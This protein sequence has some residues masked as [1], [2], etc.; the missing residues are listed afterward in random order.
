MLVPPSRLGQAT[1]ALIS[2]EDRFNRRLKYP[3]VLFTVASEF[4]DNRELFEDAKEKID[5]ITE[6]R[7]KFGAYLDFVAVAAH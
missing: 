4:K 1:E 7:A 5:A 2:V 6:G 3:Y